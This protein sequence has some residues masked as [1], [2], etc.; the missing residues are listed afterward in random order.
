M[1][2]PLALVALVLIACDEG[3]SGETAPS[4]SGDTTAVPA[5]DARSSLV[6]ASLDLL[7]RRP[8]PE[9]LKTADEAAFEA[10]IVG[11]ESDPALGRRAAWMWNDALHQAAWRDDLARLSVLEPGIM[12]SLAWE[13][14]AGIEA[15]V[16]E[17]RPMTELFSAASWPADPVVAELWG[18]PYTGENGGWGWTSYADGRPLAGLLSTNGLWMRHQADQTNFHRRRA[19]MLTRVF[20]CAD[21]FDRDVDLASDSTLGGT[22]VEEAVRSE[23]SCVTC[24]AALDPIAGFLGGFS[25]RSEPA[26]LQ[27]AGQYSPWL[28]DWAAAR[29][30]PAWFGNPGADVGDLGRFMAADPRFPRCVAQRAYEGLTGG[31]FAEA[32][33]REALVEAFVESGYRWDKLVGA[34]ARTSGWRTPELR[35][36][37]VDQRVISTT[38]ALGLAAG[39]SGAWEGL[40]ELLLEGD[41]RV[42]GGDSDDVDVLGR[43]TTAAPAHLLAAEWLARVAVP[44]ALDEDRLRAA[45]KRLL[46][47]ANEATIDEG[48]I[49]AQLATLWARLL[50]APVAADSAEI[51]RLYALWLAADPADPWGEVIEALL[52]HPMMGLH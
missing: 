50:S 41:L 17:D 13:P 24:H 34:V 28:A 26:T 27:Q 40:D 23:A 45:D 10:L 29:S 6:R 38:A 36:L 4:D 16:N 25:E 5:L 39:A 42:L 12:R 48:E 43:A 20:L 37:S 35:R 31:S 51:D 44:E 52:Q 2:P 14:L 8:P 33:E 47:P 19:N 7:G 49:R 18:L 30:P 3:K 15:I 32:P 1:P 21:F 9:A 11:A 46:L 22:D